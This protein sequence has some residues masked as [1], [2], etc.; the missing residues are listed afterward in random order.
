MKETPV[1]Y[2]QQNLLDDQLRLGLCEQYGILPKGTSA[3]YVK[4]AITPD[5]LVT[6]GAPE[7]TKNQFPD[8]SSCATLTV[9][10]QTSIFINDLNPFYKDSLTDKLI[11]LQFEDIARKAKRDIIVIDPKDLTSQFPAILPPQAFFDQRRVALLFPGKGAAVLKKYLEA[12]QPQLLGQDDRIFSFPCEKNFSPGGKYIKVNLK[13]PADFNPAQFDSFLIFDDVVATGET[14]RAIEWL[15]SDRLPQTFDWNPSLRFP[16]SKSTL[17]QIN[18]F[19][20]VSW[21]ALYPNQR[22]TIYKDTTSSSI[23]NIRS[24]S[25]TL[26]YRGGDGIPPCNSLS[27]L[28]GND[29]KAELVKQGLKAKYFPESAG[30]SFDQLIT[31]LSKG[32]NYD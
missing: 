10:P 19:K 9:P 32:A 30:E 14:A 13:F 22:P 5:R 12:Y 6:M 18:R 17:E 25:T 29:A 27:T 11:D 28:V 24:V 4:K 23:R 1:R 2:Y 21:L 31:Y 8:F 3:E 7:K 15:I 16:S 20:V 26:C